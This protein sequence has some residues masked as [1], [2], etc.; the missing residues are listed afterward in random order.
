MKPGFAESVCQVI[1][2]HLDRQRQRIHEEIR[3]YPCPIPA[4]D[5]Q[6]NQLLQERAAIDRELARLDALL[7]E[8]P[9][10][11]P[12]KL[13]N[14]FLESSCLD[15]EAKERIASSLTERRTP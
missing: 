14:D 4:C 15:H 2:A 8:G 7:E 13:L 1:R 5:L 3:D 10:G 6:F 12:L 11:D 9:G